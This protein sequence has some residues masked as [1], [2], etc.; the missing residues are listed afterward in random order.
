MQAGHRVAEATLRSEIGSLKSNM[1]FILS[2]T[3]RQGGNND[4]TAMSQQEAAMSQRA[5]RQVQQSPVNA[6]HTEGSSEATMSE[7]ARSQSRRRGAKALSMLS[8]ALKM[9]S[10]SSKLHVPA[11]GN[12]HVQDRGHQDRGQAIAQEKAIRRCSQQPSCQQLSS[13]QIS[14]LLVESSP[15]K[16]NVI[17]NGAHAA[18]VVPPGLSDQEEARKLEQV[19]IEHLIQASS[20][21][22]HN[23]AATEPRPTYFMSSRG[24]SPRR[25]PPRGVD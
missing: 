16:G 5:V 8:S 11:A 24:P 3:S 19:Q 4:E 2:Y 22:V 7:A 12:A 6:A 1:A 15:P 10:R 17:A 13:Q 23:P 18:R 9:P 25:R 14:T 21:A 20:G